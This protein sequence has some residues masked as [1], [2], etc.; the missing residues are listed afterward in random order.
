MADIA[1]IVGTRPE[2]I[3][4]SPVIRAL[5]RDDFVFIHT[6]Q[7]YDYNLSLQFI[8]DL[9]LP[10]PDVTFALTHSEPA[11]QMGEM[12]IK[13]HNAMKKIRPRIVAVE[14]DT[15]SIL[16]GGISAIKNGIRL[17]HIEAGLRSYDWRMPEEHNRIAADHMSDL[18]FAPTELSK[19]NLLNERVHGD[20]HVTGN[21]IVDAVAQNIKI[22]RSKSKID[23]PSEDF[24]LATLHRA[25]NVDD[26]ATLGNL[27]YALM[28]CPVRVVFPIHPRTMKRLKQFR[29]YEKIKRAGNIALVPPVGYFDFLALMQKCRL[30]VTDSGGI[31]EEATC[32]PI[33]KRVV[34][35]RKSTE[36][37]EAEKAGFVRIAGTDK[38][39]ITVAIDHAINNRQRLPSTSPFGDSKA[40]ER[41]VELLSSHTSS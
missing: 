7:H 2:I 31:Q 20:I 24:I 19:R 16:A 40:G 8:K 25:E 5:K 38:H 4:M 41:I 28:K 22:A 37:P 29:L 6:G 18:L 14:G 15:N 35:V 23:I 9:D 12:I 10:K 17:A 32:P 21:T 34:L 33:R 11:L 27:A 39:D 3:K 26:E 13:L 1:L 36:R 30:I